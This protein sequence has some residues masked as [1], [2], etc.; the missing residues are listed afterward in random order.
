MEGRADEPAAE[1]PAA[2][3]KEREEASDGDVAAL[4]TRVSGDEVA[5]GAEESSVVSAQGRGGYSWTVGSDNAESGSE[6]D[7]E[8]S[9]SSPGDGS[10]A[11]GG[12]S[13]GKKKKARTTLS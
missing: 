10:G 9:S 12:G 5:D 6:T 1:Q 8:Q 7:E 2:A 13:G 4:S 11:A 3:E